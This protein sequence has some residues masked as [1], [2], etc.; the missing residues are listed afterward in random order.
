[1]EFALSAAIAQE[2]GKKARGTG[3]M[4]EINVRGVTKENVEDLCWA[5]VSPEKRDDPDWIRGVADKKKW[6]IETLQKWGPF[7]KVA[8]H[9]GSPAGMIQ[10]RPLA[11]ERVVRIYCIYVQVAGHWR[12]GIATRLLGSLLED[13]EKPMKWFDSSRPLALATKTFLGGASEQYTAREFFTR[14][15]F[16]QIG[17]E[18]D[19]LYYPLKAGFVYRPVEKK[20]V[21]YIPRDEDKG[22]VVLVSGPDWCPATYPYFLKRTEKCIRET[23][24]GVAIRW[25]DSSEDPGE[26]RKRNVAVGDC[27]VN[28]RLMPSYVLDKDGFEKE[29]RAALKQ[30]GLDRGA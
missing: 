20:E 2:G 17:K 13:V 16:R 10:Y 23:Y 29:V 26:V 14:K 4:D 11:G 8:Y 15:G 21:G 19:H 1:L 28:A 27:I 5:C 9:N 7:A 12:K 22:K 3:L 30:K 25:I 18:P 24:P 6:A